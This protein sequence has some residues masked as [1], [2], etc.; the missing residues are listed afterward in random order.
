L[1]GNTFGAYGKATTCNTPCTGDS[2]AICGGGW[3]N[4]VYV[5]STSKEDYDVTDASYQGCFKDSTTRDLKE[6][7]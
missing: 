4:S 1:C 5:A 6:F 3:T 2:T 7:S